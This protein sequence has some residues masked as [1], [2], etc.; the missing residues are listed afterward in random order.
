MVMVVV[1]VRRRGV[2][3]RSAPRGHWRRRGRQQQRAEAARGRHRRAPAAP[4]M[5]VPTH[6][7]PAITQ[8]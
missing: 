3:A 6:V 7:P 8:C 2:S 5:W 1:V 4:P